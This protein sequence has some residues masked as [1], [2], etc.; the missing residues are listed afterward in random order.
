MAVYPDLVKPQPGI[1]DEISQ[2]VIF[3]LIT[4]YLFGKKS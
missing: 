3:L 2:E 4:L 1:I